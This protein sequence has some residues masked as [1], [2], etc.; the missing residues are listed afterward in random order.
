MIGFEPFFIKQF[1]LNPKDLNVEFLILA[2][3]FIELIWLKS[4]ITNKK[5]KRISSMQGIFIKVKD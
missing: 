5:P 2:R 4:I 3:L 1:L